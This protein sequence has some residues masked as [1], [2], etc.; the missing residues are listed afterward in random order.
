MEPNIRITITYKSGRTDDHL[1]VS[2]N[3]KL[4]RLIEKAHRMMDEGIVTN[5]QR[6]DISTPQRG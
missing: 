1:F 4:I 2:E 5:V 6:F 3:K